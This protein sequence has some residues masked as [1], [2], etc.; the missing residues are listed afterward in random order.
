MSD[1]S[2]ASVYSVTGYMY[3]N[4]DD[5]STPAKLDSHGHK[6]N[7]VRIGT[8][9]YI[10]D[11]TNSDSGSIGQSGGLF[12]NGMLYDSANNRY[13]KAFSGKTLYYQYEE[14]LTNLFDESVL[15]LSSSDYQY[16]PET[17]P[18]DKIR[19]E[20]MNLTLKDDIA[21]NFYFS[22][23]N[24]TTTGDSVTF[25]L[26]NGLFST[27]LLTDMIKK[28]VTDGLTG[29][30]STYYVCSVELAAKDMTYE[31]PMYVSSGSAYGVTKTYSIR[32]Y[33]NAVLEGNQYTET[34]K[35]LVKAMLNYGA[36]AQ[37]YFGYNTENLA[38]STVNNISIE[39]NIPTSSVD[40]SSFSIDVSSLNGSVGFAGSSL[41]LSGKTS[42]K[43][44][45]DKTAT[46][47]NVSCTNDSNVQVDVI[48]SGDGQY[49]IVRIRNI[50]PANLDTSF[51]ISMSVGGASKT[52][53]VN[54]MA[55]G[56]A[57][58]NMQDRD[59]LKNLVKALRLY[60][61]AAKAIN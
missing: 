48:E 1:F 6:W 54:P 55:Y 43:L 37:K 58:L 29:K 60:N 31:V 21:M 51:T 18:D 53:S 61:Q 16:S 33:A 28:T 35:S 47:S 41:V 14:D 32:Q 8:V 26:S 10:A 25:K 7:L 57:V 46:I 3:D 30:T 50:S 52:I 11:V 40:L 19:L 20:G 56:K 27:Y 23:S 24:S 15:V 45:F 13:Y 49:Q 12:L 59:S 17:T 22:D 39:D 38:N 2:N 9:N 44:Y 4:T 42:M 36:Y 34:Q 5:V